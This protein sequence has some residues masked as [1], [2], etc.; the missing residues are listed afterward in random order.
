M[1]E[2]KYYHYNLLAHI[3]DISIQRLI[4]LPKAERLFEVDAPLSQISREMGDT[5]SPYKP[6][7]LE[8][9][10]SPTFAIEEASTLITGFEASMS[11][12]S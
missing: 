3:C 6:L 12:L 9:H 7:M 2:I 11:Q 4:P 10:S 1:N 8:I 5:I